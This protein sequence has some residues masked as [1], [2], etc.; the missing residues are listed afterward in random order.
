[1]LEIAAL[2]VVS[3]HVL[4]YYAILMHFILTTFLVWTKIDSLQVSI[5][6]SDNNAYK[7]NNNVYEGM[8]ISAM[9]M[10]T[11]RA[12][13]MMM[14]GNRLTFSSCIMLTLDIMACFFIVWI[15]LDGLIWTSYG[16]IYGF[17]V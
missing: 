4:R 2:D 8:I 12:L 13:F 1:M 17:C 5:Y 7:E 9:V 11:A 14:E 6:Y 16:Y 10:L 3:Y 15:I